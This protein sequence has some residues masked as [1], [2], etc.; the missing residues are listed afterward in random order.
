EKI[1][2]DM[3]FVASFLSITLVLA[4]HVIILSINHN[5]HKRIKLL[6]EDMNTLKI[7]PSEKDG[8]NF[9]SQEQ[10]KKIKADR[11]ATEEIFFRL[12]TMHTKQWCFT[13]M[14]RLEDLLI[15]KGYTQ[16]GMVLIKAF[17][18]WK[19][20]RLFSE[21][22]LDQLHKIPEKRMWQF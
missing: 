3:L 19:T 15:F 1:V 21:V 11:L 2:K 12:T 10:I 9:L 16:D 13:E 18:H 5:I 7:S 8:L 14:R 20:N 4:V 6:R 17:D 22:R